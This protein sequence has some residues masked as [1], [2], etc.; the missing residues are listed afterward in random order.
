MKSRS[1]RS[2]APSPNDEFLEFTNSIAFDQRL[3]KYDIAGSIAHAHTLADA[4][5]LTADE[6]RRVT[7]G[8]RK[9]ARDL[10]DGSASFD[11]GLENVHMAVERMLTERIGEPGMKLHTGRSRNDQVALDMRLYARESIAAVLSNLAELQEALLMRAS[12]HVDVIMPGMTHMQHAQPVLLSH[13]LMAYFWKFQRDADRL[14]DCY[15][16][17]NISPLGSGAIAGTS[18]PFDR[19][20]AV[21][22]LGMEGVTENSMDAVS[23]RDFVAETSFALSLLMVHLSSLCEEII[24]WASPE[25]GFV[26]LPDEMSSGSSM[27]PQKRNPDLPELI[28]AKSGR[29]VGDVVTV[30]TLLK[31]LPLAY[32]RDLQEDKECLF[33]AVDT[34][35]ASLHALIPFL[36]AMRFDEV[37][38]RKAAGV[39]LTTAT[40]LA[41]FLTKHGVPFRKAHGIVR[42][43]AKRANGD[44]EKFLH[45][46]QSKLRSMESMSGAVASLSLED[47][48]ESRDIEGGTSTKAV[49]KQM[50][51]AK[52]ALA[53]TRALMK[54]MTEQTSLVDRVLLKGS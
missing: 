49:R 25:F 35:K 52:E 43:L 31:S 33:D 41:D 17:A 26:L 34:V 20:I 3:W 53:R 48:V 12:A 27:M 4:G 28:R 54:R 50:I 30:L 14:C 24:M 21:A 1:K 6:L 40:D 37:R 11:P 39:G 46:A 32:N 19:S 45:L 16:R 7:A 47:S 9:I 18:Y 2:R 22:M 23:D 51:K 44:E 42:E 15:R 13:H 10:K 36:Q 5:V 8:L 38:M 29:V